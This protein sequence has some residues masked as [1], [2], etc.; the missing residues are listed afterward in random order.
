MNQENQEQFKNTPVTHFIITD[1]DGT[2]MPF[3]KLADKD[4][5]KPP[6]EFIEAIR[7]QSFDN[8]DIAF[9][10]LTGR[11]AWELPALYE[12]IFLPDYQGRKPKI[13][14]AS[15]NGAN[16]QFEH[17]DKN[18]LSKNN[19]KH[20]NIIEISKPL[21]DKTKADIENSIINAI[22]IGHY[23]TNVKD[24]APELWIKAEVKNFGF[25]FHT[26]LPIIKS[27]LAEYNKAIAK[28]KVSLRDYGHENSLEVH[29][30]AASALTIEKVSKGATVQRI[31]TRDKSMV[32]IFNNHG[33]TIGPIEKIFFAG[34]D[35]GD[36]SAHNVVN[37]ALGKSEI[38][39]FTSKPSNYTRYDSEGRTPNSPTEPTAAD[40]F[41]IGS[42]DLSSQKQVRAHFTDINKA[43]ESDILCDLRKAL[44]DIGLLPSQSVKD[45]TPPIILLTTGDILI[46]KPEDYPKASL[47][48]LKDWT[49]GKVI[50]CFTNTNTNVKIQSKN[51]ISIIKQKDA[52][53]LIINENK[54]AIEKIVF[55]SLKKSNKTPSENQTDSETYTYLKSIQE[56]LIK[57][58]T[59]NYKTPGTYSLDKFI[60]PT[61][62]KDS[63]KNTGACNKTNENS[64]NKRPSL[65]L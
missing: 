55:D 38:K 4:N 18:E 30:D 59:I 12:N 62:G 35:K 50:L 19:K 11:Q 53:S 20:D 57:R 10:V 6:K 14:L 45:N 28:I 2:V 44:H 24:K 23:T 17:I 1:S 43:K 63:T 48:K 25:T 16:M 37:N 36:E 27:E 49:L 22:G 3:S 54:Q 8:P 26:S 58:G 40:F 52:I 39:G 65:L 29:P 13:V 15:E 47:E 33:I 64:S 51:I 42:P 32:N 9:M 61:I 60:T 41:I 5:A 46:Q 34:D 31:L 7:Q 56:L 21:D